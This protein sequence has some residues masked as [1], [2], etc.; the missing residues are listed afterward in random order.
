MT[1]NSSHLYVQLHRWKSKVKFYSIFPDS[2]MGDKQANKSGNLVF[3][4]ILLIFFSKGRSKSL[5]HFLFIS[6]HF[7]KTLT[8]STLTSL[9][10]WTN[11]SKSSFF[12]QKFNFDF[13]TVFENHPKCRIWIF[14]FWHFPPI[15]DLLKLTC[16]VTL[17]DRKL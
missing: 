8:L 1:Q 4:V 3:S 14:E 2:L 17:F 10:I 7:G 6:T 5:H 13:H 16:L 15:F 9:Q 11:C 12:V